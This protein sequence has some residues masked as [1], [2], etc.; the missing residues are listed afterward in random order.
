MLLFKAVGA[1][2][3]GCEY[4]LTKALIE[5]A[6]ALNLATYLLLKSEQPPP[7]RQEGAS[8]SLG[9][10]PVLSQLRKLHN[11]SAQLEAVSDKVPGLSD[12]LDKLVQAAALMKG[13]L[14]IDDESGMDGRGEDKPEATGRSQDSDAESSDDR[15]EN[16][17][18]ASSAKVPA[19]A[20]PSRLDAAPSS[21]SSSD[22][23][24]DDEEARRKRVL[25]EARFALRPKEVEDGAVAIPRK[26]RPAPDFGED[27]SGE[28]EFTGKKK[29]FAAAL[30][31]IQQR[32]A[33]PA[34]RSR[35]AEDLDDFMEREGDFT[36]GDDDREDF[37]LHGKGRQRDEASDEEYDEALDPELEED[38]GGDFYS[39]VARK[40]KSRKEA[41]KA[42]HKVAPK[43][44]RVEQE[45]D[46]ERALSR[47]IL[48]NR[49]L[50][51]HKNRLNRNPRVK[52]REQFR[53]ALVRRRGAVREVRTDE[54]HKYGGEQTGIK[55]GLSRSRKL[56]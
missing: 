46:G 43:Y 18:V 4:L 23:D 55:T 20:A 10:H 21:S 49:G 15:D 56:L 7:H 16:L 11:L 25:D 41:R 8:A 48:K 36:A 22:S 42:M 14:S 39:L 6:S 5:T 32:S 54:G 24:S 17:G 37:R 3:L 47:Q 30:N 12:Q 26:R 40:S 19:K 52:K 35:L 1:T 38:G 29:A 34:K 45:I 2:P 51:P 31:S 53:R 33:K 50:V 44:P 13:D 9:S 28:Q 27:V